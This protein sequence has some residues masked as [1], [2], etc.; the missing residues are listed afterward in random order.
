VCDDE[1]DVGEETGEFVLGEVDIGRVHRDRRARFPQLGQ[2]RRDE[3]GQGAGQARDADLSHLLAEVVLPFRLNAGDRRGHLPTSGGQ[4]PPGRGQPQTAAGR[5][6][7]CLPEFAG[8]CLELLGH[9]R[10]GAERRLR[11]GRDAAAFVELPQQLEMPGIHNFRLRGDRTTVKSNC[12][13]ML[14]RF[15]CVN[16]DGPTKMGT[17]RSNTVF[18]PPRWR[19]CGD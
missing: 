17:C 6:D 4:Q 8:R 2:G 7:E 15:D 16:N 19:S 14:E 1:V 11:N 9:R 13:V 3:I 5:F 10:R 18:S 12:M